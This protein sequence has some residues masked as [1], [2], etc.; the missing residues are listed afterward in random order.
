MFFFKLNY[1]KHHNLTSS[2]DHLADIFIHSYIRVIILTP[3]RYYIKFRR[4]LQ[5]FPP[6]PFWVE[7]NRVHYC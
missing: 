7:W 1:F 6:P 5:I 3:I 4:F 2:P